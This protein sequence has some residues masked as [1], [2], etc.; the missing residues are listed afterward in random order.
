MAKHRI[1]DMP[2]EKLMVRDREQYERQRLELIAQIDQ[3]QALLKAERLKSAKL[4]YQLQE[5]RNS[6]QA[7]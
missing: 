6:S 1:T 5:L 7:A 3:L 4:Q 2:S